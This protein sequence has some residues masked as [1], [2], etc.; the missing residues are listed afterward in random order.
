MLR[1]MKIYRKE[2]KYLSYKRPFITL[3]E[4]M[5]M[6][7]IIDIFLMNIFLIL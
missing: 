7:F 3:L 5:F 6:I 2:K 4:S 1:K